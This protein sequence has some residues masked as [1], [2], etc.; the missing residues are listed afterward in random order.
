MET[1]ALS[2]SHE[3]DYA[4]LETQRGAQ[5]LEVIMKVVRHILRIVFGIL[6]LAG[7]AL[8]WLA[9]DILRDNERKAGAHQARRTRQSG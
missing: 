6:M 7:G 5:L 1:Q 3:A 2:G 9:N 4:D 8:L